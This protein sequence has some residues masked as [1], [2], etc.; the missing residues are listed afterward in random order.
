MVKYEVY[1][2]LHKPSKMI[3]QF[4]NNWYKLLLLGFA[5]YTLWAKDVSFQFA[6]NDRITSS[7]TE[8]GTISKVQSVGEVAAIP[9]AL[10][11]DLESDQLA[12][13]A[14]PVSSKEKK[15]TW[16]ASTY[17]NIGFVL[18]PNYA[19]KHNVD[20]AIVDHHLAVCK[21]YLRRFAKVA[22]AEQR[23]YGVPASITLAQGLLES[24]AGGSRLAVESNNHFGMK[25]RSKCKGCTCR[26]YSD[27]SEYDMF[28]VFDSAWESY[29]A[30]SKLMLDGRYKHL[31]KLE[32][33]N[34]IAWAHG[35]KK[36]GY[37]TDKRYAY[38]LIDLIERL[39]LHRFD[40]IALSK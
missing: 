19:T 27:D 5:A 20:Q 2:P 21:N 30:H 25:C 8:V 36:A 18:N 3:G 6:L 34:Y 26:N 31:L 13:A 15:T 29:R 7:P 33:T 39:Q 22:I 12:V 38:K 10:L 23:K 17:S 28:R 16:K 40:E 35:L 1:N 24:D 4:N 37:A 32:P 9:V 14:M 11:S